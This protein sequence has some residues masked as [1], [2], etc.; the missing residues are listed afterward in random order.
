MLYFALAMHCSVT[1]HKHTYDHTSTSHATLSHASHAL[2]PVHFAQTHLWSHP[3]WQQGWAHHMGSPNGT[4]DEYINIAPPKVA[5]M[6]TTHCTNAPVITPPIAAGMSTPHGIPQ[7]H[8]GWVHQ[9]CTPKGSRDEYISL[10]KRTSD[11]TPN[12]SR[13]EYITW[14]FKQALRRD[15]GALRELCQHLALRHVRPAK[16]NSINNLE[17]RS[18]HMGQAYR[19]DD[20]ADHLSIYIPSLYHGVAQCIQHR[21]HVT[22]QTFTAPVQPFIDNISEGDIK[23][24]VW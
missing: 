4:R 19:R 18:Y 17:T 9:H 8:Q 5:G 23:G 12:C 2:V 1:L 6:S 24:F 3:Q 14:D 21:S 11:H 22:W 13:D 16:R 10:H 15:D 20:G 7:W